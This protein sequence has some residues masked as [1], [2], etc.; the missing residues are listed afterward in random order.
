MRTDSA[1]MPPKPIAVPRLTADLCAD[2]SVVLCDLDGCLIS[3]GRAFDDAP[4]FVET[5]REKLWIVSNNS[6]D[7]AES[8]GNNLTEMGI[9]VPAER[10][11]LSGEQT[12]RHLAQI[13]PKARLSLYA[14][15]QLHWIADALGF[16]RD[17]GAPDL[18]LLCR[19]PAFTLDTLDR[20]ICD[21]EQGAEFWISNTDTAHPGL[22]GR[23]IAETG[24]LFAA[25]NAILPNTAYR[26]LGKPDPF[27][28]EW[29]LQATGAD[30]GRAV[31][32]GDNAD[33]DGVA[34]RTVDIPF[35]HL[36]REGDAW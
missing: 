17:E 34:A 7:T 19:D 32:I 5:C 12:L 33:T 30:P 13:R 21:I 10:I 28:L 16:A 3:Q 23:R 26:C 9:S 11:L 8:L 2:A 29:A 24:A 35:I 31:F 14:D 22:D 6:S 20:L 27:L 4:A 15:P 36:I 18:V 1:L 25:V